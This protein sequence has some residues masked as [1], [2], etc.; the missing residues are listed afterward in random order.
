MKKYALYLLISTLSVTITSAG[1]FI[2]Y[3]D[4]YNNKM[5]DIF[6]C[7]LSGGNISPCLKN[8]H[9]EVF[10]SKCILNNKKRSDC[11]CRYD[12]LNDDVFPER[13][14]ALIKTWAHKSEKELYI[15]YAK[16]FGQNVLYEAVGIRADVSKKFFDVRKAAY[17]NIA[18][19]LLNDMSDGFLKNALKNIR[20]KAIGY[21]MANATANMNIIYA[22]LVAGGVASNYS[23]Y[24]VVIDYH[25]GGMFSPIYEYYKRYDETKNKIDQ[26]ESEY[27]KKYKKL[28]SRYASEAISK[29]SKSSDGMGAYLTNI[30]PHFSNSKDSSNK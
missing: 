7:M 4:K 28:I 13:F 26:V 19:K 1:I 22:S 24:K 25:C 14:D 2:Y 23:R 29:L 30:I 3:S 21:R 15:T 8:P 27:Y 6:A 5:K 10:I 16:I 9:K 11:S 18:R 17:G 12:A 20:S